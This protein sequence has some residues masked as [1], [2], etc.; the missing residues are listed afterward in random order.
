MP[1]TCGG[2]LSFVPLG[3]MVFDGWEEEMVV[4]LLPSGEGKGESS[5]RMMCLLP[6]PTSARRSV[7]HW[8]IW[9]RSRGGR[10]V[11]TVWSVVMH[12]A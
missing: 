7:H 6:R 11:A 5:C 2:L 12:D 4:L 9:A 3:M 10:K 8:D 1:I